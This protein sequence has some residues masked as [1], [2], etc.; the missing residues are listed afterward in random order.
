MTNVAYLFA[1]QGAQRVG[2]GKELCAA[3]PPA[4][5][6]FGRASE[7]LGFD[8]AKVCFEGP[9]E[10]LNRTDVCQPALLVH[11]VAAQRWFDGRRRDHSV[12]AAAGLSL[13]EYSAHVYAGSFSLED[14][15]RLVMLR[16]RYMQEACD[17]TASG[18]TAVLR[19]DP[20]KVDEACKAAGGIVG[21]ANIN[22]PGEI[23]ISGE[24]EAL[25]RA[26]EK[27]KA[28]GAKR[29]IPL[30]VAGAY[31]SE[32]MRPAQEKMQ[33]ELA[34]VGIAKPRVPVWA[35]VS[36]KPVAEPEEI[37]DTLGRQI[38]STVLWND[39]IAAVGVTQF[40]EFGPGRVLAGLAKKIL[41]D[42]ET[43]SVE[44]PDES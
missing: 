40:V 44:K 7:V 25:E 31:H 3:F 28:A 12:A 20:A 2:M 11:A 34:K 16:G 39:T 24:K 21:I 19:L 8:L 41:P 5:E 30:R 13:G 35:N 22:A 9:Q 43:V 36:A 37:R 29:C 4:K 17:A 15:V 10:R 23:V 14:G 1:G 18:M 26:A 6:I 42:S 38:C 32:I 33:A 27:C